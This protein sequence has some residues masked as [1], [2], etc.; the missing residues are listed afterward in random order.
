MDTQKI[1]KADRDEV[2][3][4]WL[5]QFKPEDIIGSNLKGW[6]SDIEEHLL[7][8]DYSWCDMCKT[9]AKVSTL[10][11]LQICRDCEVDS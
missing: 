2:L 6:P 9:I 1:S 10:S 3:N 4:D 8:R 11:W 7:D 5:D